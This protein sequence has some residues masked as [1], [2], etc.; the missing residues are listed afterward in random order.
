M[1]QSWI[2]RHD[3]V[4]AAEVEKA[5]L[6]YHGDGAVSRGD[7][8]NRYI[9][10]KGVF[11]RVIAFAYKPTLGISEFAFGE[12]LPGLSI[13]LG[14]EYYFEITADRDGVLAC[15]LRHKARWYAIP[16]S[17]FNLFTPCQEGKNLVPSTTDEAGIDPLVEREDQ[18]LHEFAFFHASLAHQLAPLG[19]W[20]GRKPIPPSALDDAAA[21]LQTVPEGEISILRINLLVT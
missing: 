3:P 5:V 16:L 6:E 18:G 10:R 1:L 19:S 12:P 15:L 11:E 2:E 8:W 9:K 7:S 14:R 17:R 13:E 20:S 4:L 21:H